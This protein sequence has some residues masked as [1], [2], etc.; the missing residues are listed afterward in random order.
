MSS[1]EEYEAEYN[2]LW[3][4]LEAAD[5][6]GKDAGTLVGRYIQE[7]RGDGYAIYQVVKE[8]KRTVRIKHVEIGDAWVVPMW[9]GGCS[10]PKQWAE[11]NIYRRDRMDELF[12]KRLAIVPPSPLPAGV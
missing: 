9:G 3:A 5:Q 6:A 1:W 2:R 10:L 8:N 12:P 4:A 11:Q 7:P